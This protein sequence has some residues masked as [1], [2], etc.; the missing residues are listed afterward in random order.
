MIAIQERVTRREIFQLI[1]SSIQELHPDKVI[2]EDMDGSPFLFKS[3][4][5]QVWARI[6]YRSMRDYSV[7]ELQREIKKLWVMMPNDATLYLFYPELDRQQIFRMNGFSDRLS[8][9]E[10]AGLF[11]ADREKFSARI[12][13]WIPSSMSALSLAQEGRVLPRVRISTVSFLQSARLTSQEIA[14]LAELSMA[15]HR[16]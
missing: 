11:G 1:R 2:L 5:A 12:C 7:E 4:D 15:L 13:K 6:F 16:V 3:K 8:F 14:G 9:F 10:Y